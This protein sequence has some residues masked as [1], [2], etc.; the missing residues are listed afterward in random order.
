MSSGILI[1]LRDWSIWSKILNDI[2]QL[3][4]LQKRKFRPEVKFSLI[5]DFHLSEWLIIRLT[6]VIVG[7]SLSVCL[8]L[9]NEMKMWEEKSGKFRKFYLALNMTYLTWRKAHTG[10]LQRRFQNFPL[11]LIYIDIYR[12]IYIYIYLKVELISKTTFLWLWVS[13]LRD[14]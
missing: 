11:D 5:M 12:Y 7:N 4:T 6:Y 13:R 2:M 1:Y 9:L 14:H 8:Y 10:Q 3:N